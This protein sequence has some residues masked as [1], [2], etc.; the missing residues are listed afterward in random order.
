MRHR[1]VIAQLRKEKLPSSKYVSIGGGI[2]P[3]ALFDMMKR[4]PPL[5]PYVIEF[6]Q[7]GYGGAP[8]RSA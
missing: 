6:G 2:K 4:P 7:K 5:R 1:R 3:V 8:R